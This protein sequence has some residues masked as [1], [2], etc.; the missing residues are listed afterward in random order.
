V[1]LKSGWLPSFLNLFGNR[2]QVSGFGMY[3]LIEI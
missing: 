2:V 3:V 1:P